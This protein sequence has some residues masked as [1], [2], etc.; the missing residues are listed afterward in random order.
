L[1]AVAPNTA[2]RMALSVIRI[3]GSVVSNACPLASRGLAQRLLFEDLLVVL[4]ALAV[5]RRVS[6]LRRR[7]W[8]APSSANTERTEIR[9]R[10]GWMLP[11]SSMWR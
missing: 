1:L 5:E 9:L 6:S 8:S 3:I 10:L 11:T 4:D 2:R 7:R